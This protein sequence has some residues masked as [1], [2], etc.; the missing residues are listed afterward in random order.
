[1]TWTDWVVVGSYVLGSLAIGLFRRRARKNIEEYFIKA[2][3][4]SWWL[5]GVWA[6]AAYTQAGFVAA[7]AARSHDTS[8]SCANR[9]KLEFAEVDGYHHERRAG[10]GPPYIET[11]CIWF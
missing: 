9:R 6:V 5:L 4:P 7:A 1:V 11:R 10:V 2:R 8:A 3:N